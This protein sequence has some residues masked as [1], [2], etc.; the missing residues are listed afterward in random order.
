[1]A[2]TTALFTGLAGLNSNARQLDVIG[3]NISNVNT[4]A[5]KSNRLQFSSAFNRT[6]SLGTSPNASTGGSN[7]G[8]IGLGVTMAGTQRNF[9][10]GAISPTGLNTDLAIEGN[11]FFVV[12]RSGER[13]FTRSGA[14]QFNSQND[15]VT[16][17]GD[18]LQGYPIDSEFNIIEGRVENVNI[19]M[20]TL[21]IAEATQNVTFSGNLNADGDVAQQ[22]SIISLGAFSDS[23]GPPTP[24]SLLTDLDPAGSFVA[25]NVIELRQ[26]ERGGKVIPTAE[27]EVTPTSTLGE[28]MDW[29]RVNLG[30]YQNGGDDP[31]D[32][33]GVSTDGGVSLGGVGGD[34]IVIV[35][36][37]GSIN[38]LEIDASDIFIR[39]GTA[40]GPP[41]NAT[42]FAPVKT[43]VADGESVR[44]TFIVYDSL[45]TELQV[46]LT[47]VLAA[48]TDGGTFWRPFMHSDDDTDAA[49]L[50]ENG[51]LFAAGSEDMPLL[52]FDNFGQLA[53]LGQY[54]IQVD[55]QDTGALDP[56]QIALRFNSQ[57]DQVSAL[58]NTGGGST[59]AA[60]F[61]DGSPLGVLSSFSVGENGTITGG[62]TNGLTRT[63]GQLAIASFTNPEGLVDSGNN[64]FSVGPN[65]GTPLITEPLEF[66]TGRIIG[67]AL[68]LSNVDLSQ[69]FINMI[70]TST[71][72]SAASRVVT[73]TNELMNQLLVLGR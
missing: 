66:G 35:G 57:A 72:Y 54:N 71:G 9:S 29:L 16:L 67:G 25:G 1:M 68:E 40:A 27:F 44:T 31:T 65:S 37:P 58:S 24:A 7:P 8:Q 6:F 49:N 59:L 39:Q 73:T 20:G 34:E 19:P 60:V 21:T 47:L 15:L 22:G 69:E 55:R 17:S 4:T 53:T 5:Y 70:L 26:A 10:N 28:Y 45:G 33:A 38:D 13:F 41:P 23:G 61:Q 62:F 46:D 11:G 48:K 56:L 64:L 36:N 51:T 63:I 42:P 2:S 12:E 18:R 32:P 14:F 52:Q 50:L 3:N 43:Q 30:I